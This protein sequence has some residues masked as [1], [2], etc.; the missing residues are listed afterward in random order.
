[1]AN[2]SIFDGKLL[3]AHYSPRVFAYYFKQWEQF[4]MPFHRHDSMEIMYVIQGDCVVE[5]IESST[6]NG[7]EEAVEQ[8]KLAKGEFIMLD[9]N[10][11][12]RLIVDDKCRMLN[13]EFGFEEREAEYFPS[14][15]QMAED[16]RSLR[17]L[18]SSQSS[19]LRLRDSDEVYHCLRSLVLELDGGSGGGKLLERLLISQLLVR[20]SRLKEMSATSGW[21]PTEQYVRSCMEFLGQ[22]YDRPI[23]VRDVAV[24]VSL[25]PGYLQRI[26]KTHT[27]KTI[28]EYVTD[29]RMEKAKMLLLH[30][31][32]PVADISDYVGTGSRQYFHA[33]FKKHTGRTPIEYRL[34]MDKMKFSDL[35]K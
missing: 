9:A 34:S 25:H 8:T 11:S 7:D 1:M 21:N 10:L 2:G 23:A 26:F 4:H 19:Y 12:H 5:W 15:K 18:V 32:I 28:M 16:E 17:A 6:F 29:I 20:I 30:T 3:Q 13:V 27:G 24:H 35:E 31:D 33:L 22:N 14:I